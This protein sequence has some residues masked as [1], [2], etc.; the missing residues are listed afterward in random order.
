MTDTST[1]IDAYVKLRDKRDALKKQQAEALR[2]YDDKLE[3]IER[4]LM[5]V[6]HDAGTESL[7][8]KYGT[9]F[10]ASWT[11]AKVED[12]EKVLDFATE[13]GRF[14]LFERRVAK[15]VVEELGTVPGVTVERGLR[16][17]VRRAS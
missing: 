10:M 5:Q 9:A 4:R 13:H 12:W 17:N 6:M 16:L 15:S 2:V 8:T 1:Y 7:K 11:S 3:E 14:D